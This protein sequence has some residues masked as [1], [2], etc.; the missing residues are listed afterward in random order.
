MKMRA[1]RII[2]PLHGFVAWNGGLDLA[3]SM[4]SALHAVAAERDLEIC[5]AVPVPTLR[6]RLF[7]T[8]VRRWQ[9]L[10][11]GDLFKTGPRTNAVLT[12]AVNNIISQRNAIN[13][14]ASTK[15]ILRAAKLFDA[16]IIFPSM[17]PLGP[18]PYRR[19]GYI[20]DFQHRH[21]PHYFSQR[22]RR[23]RDRRFAAIAKD[24]DCIV[25]NAR[26]AAEDAQNFLGLPKQR[27]LTTPFSPHAL[28]SWF[29]IDSDEIRFLYGIG[30][31]FLMVCNH[32][33][34]HKDHETA[35]RAFARI[36][37]TA[38]YEDLE[39][40]LTGDPVDHRDPA[41]YGRLVELA[42]RLG[43]SANVHFLG[44]VPKRHQL[45]LLRASGALLQPTRF[46]GGPGG[47]SVAEA[48][49]LGVPAVVSDIPVN[50]EIDVGD[51]TF[52][53]AGDPQDLA[54]ATLACLASAHIRPTPDMAI[55]AG[56]RNLVRL[57]QTIAD[58]LARVAGSQAP[59]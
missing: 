7:A 32:F 42:S 58:C 12:E 5:F 59:M 51:V 34:V 43:L 25:V 3:R 46:E 16:D 9:L 45:A 20:F 31:R 18:A 2:F 10:R 28:P 27:I 38:G 22:T 11:A 44:L 33:W 29:E 49:G 35:L 56:Q 52:F 53:S 48:I 54:R 4:S 19:V 57:G 55:A 17:L 21:L 40:V 41:H 1:L 13:C 36:R 14:E 23:N 6:Q 47:G 37:E 8:A 39:L 30:R 15:G 26:A 50:L 24:A